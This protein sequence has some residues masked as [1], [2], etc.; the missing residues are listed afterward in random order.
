[1]TEQKK[2]Y[3]GDDGRL[4]FNYPV[5]AEYEFRNSAG[6]RFSLRIVACEYEDGKEYYYLVSAGRELPARFSVE[7]L[8][9]QLN[10]MPYEIISEGERQELPLLMEEVQT[11]YREKSKE[12]N[13]AN[14]QA[15]EKL[16]G[17]NYKKLIQLNAK[18][19]KRLWLA[20]SDGRE[21]D[22]AEIMKLIQEN[23]AACMKIIEDKGVDINALTKQRKC[24]FCR[25]TGVVNGAICICAIDNAESIK[26]F[27]AALRLEERAKATDDV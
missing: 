16:N 17:T 12:L 24:V 10:A 2:P 13:F 8:E 1:M 15:N 23:T 7:K 18:L 22:A 11:Y 4:Y 19:N 20:Q 27:N 6:A 14:V 21:D 5:G 3:V 26:A 25:D 9:I